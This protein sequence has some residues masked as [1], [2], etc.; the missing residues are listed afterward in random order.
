MTGPDD[1]QAEQD[2]AN[3]EHYAAE[4]RDDHDQGA[5]DFATCRYC[6]EDE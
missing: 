3:R 5:C 6:Q 1:D 2:Q 4:A